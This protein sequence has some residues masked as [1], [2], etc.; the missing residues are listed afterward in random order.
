V[1]VAAFNGRVPVLAVLIELAMSDVRMVGKPEVIQ[2]A[3]MFG[4]IS[5]GREEHL[6]YKC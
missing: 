1:T 2:L 4:W 5:R 6:V 3:V